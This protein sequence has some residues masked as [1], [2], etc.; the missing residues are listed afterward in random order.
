MWIHCILSVDFG[1]D[2]VP[3]N[4]ANL[5]LISLQNQLY[6]QLTVRMSFVKP[7]DPVVAQLLFDLGNVCA[8]TMDATSG[9]QVYQSAKEYGCKSDLFQKR[10]SYFERLQFKAD[11]RNNTRG[12]AKEHPMI[13]LVIADV[14]FFGGLA[15]VLFLFIRIIKRRYAKRSTDS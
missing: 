6:D 1:D 14:I 13:A 3:V 2:K 7:K 11:F 8:L 10:I 9:L 5:D 12:W 4:N 15:G